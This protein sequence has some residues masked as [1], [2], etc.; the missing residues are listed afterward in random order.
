MKHIGIWLDKEKARIVTIENET[1][2]FTTIN[3]QVENFHP[4]GGFGLGFRGSPQEA[5]PDNKYMKREKQQ[6]KLYFKDLATKIKDADAIVIFG[7]AQTGRKFRKELQEHFKDIN[8][9]V[10]G[11][12]KAN[13]LTDNQVKSWVKDFFNLKK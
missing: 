6:L 2:L 11:V 5:L 12:I 13:S 1:E 10:K 7:P 9:K 4:S 3:S 8:A